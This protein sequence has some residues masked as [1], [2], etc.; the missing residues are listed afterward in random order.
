L[1]PGTF[2]FT[3]RWRCRPGAPHA[4]PLT[5]FDCQGVSA[6]RRERVEAPVE[7]AGQR[8]APPYEAWIAAGLPGA[9]LPSRVR[10]ASKGRSR[11]RATKRIARSAAGRR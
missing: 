7:A 10:R 5:V 9:A 1:P 8:L 6:T 3:D 2:G 4:T 11:S